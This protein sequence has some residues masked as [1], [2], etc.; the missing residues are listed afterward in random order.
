MAACFV[1]LTV[2]INCILYARGANPPIG[3]L[4][5]TVTYTGRGVFPQ[6]FV[7]KEECVGGRRY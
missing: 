4:E 7:D 1:R 3:I 2:A 5:V 6:L